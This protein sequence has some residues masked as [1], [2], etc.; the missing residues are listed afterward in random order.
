V[1]LWNLQTSR[2]AP[3]KRDQ[4]IARRYLHG[5]TQTQNNRRQTSCLEWDSTH[6]PSVWASE[7][8]SLLIPWGHCDRPEYNFE[9]VF[10][11]LKK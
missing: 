7:N 3:R 9:C 6:H 2:R 8:I 1:K 5:T 11:F 4:P 10:F